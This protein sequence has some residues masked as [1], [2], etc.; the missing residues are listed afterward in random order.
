MQSPAAQAICYHHIPLPMIGKDRKTLLF[1]SASAG[2]I[3]ITRF[4]AQ[5]I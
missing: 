4:P 5:M 2:E 1:N 3:A